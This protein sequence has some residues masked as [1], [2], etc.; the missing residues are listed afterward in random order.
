MKRHPLPRQIPR[1]F[2]LVELLVVAAVLALLAGLLASRLRRR[3][4]MPGHKPLLW[5]P[6]VLTTP[7]LSARPTGATALRARRRNV[8]V[9]E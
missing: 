9:R 7:V 1:G 3:L 8:S 4:G 6:I 2:T 5:M